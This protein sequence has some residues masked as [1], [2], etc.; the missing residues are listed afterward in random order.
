[1]RADG[2]GCSRPAAPRTPLLSFVD[3]GTASGG[4]P[5]AELLRPGKAGSNTA[6][7]HVVVLDTALAKLPAPLRARDAAGRI[8]V[9]VRTDAAGATKEFA[10]HLHA[11]GVEFSVGASFAHLDVATALAAIPT[12][13]WTP[14]YQARK[15][16]AAE[17]GMQIEPRDGAWVAEATGLIPLAGWPAG[18]RLILRKERDFSST[19]STTARS[20]GLWWSPTTSTTF[21]TN[22][23]SLTA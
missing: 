2:V 8:P 23:G 14:A 10:A 20:G 16:R 13:A 21:S 19:E 6:A 22:S 18:T 11:R 3:H 5:V 9:L 17:T 1:M 15:P 4:E 12:R 7:N